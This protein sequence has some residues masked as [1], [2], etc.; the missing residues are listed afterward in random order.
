[1]S[2]Q[3]GDSDRSDEILAEQTRLWRSGDCVTV[4]RLLERYPELR[5]MPSI[6][7]DLIYNEFLLRADSGE[8]PSQSDFYQRFPE[9][10]DE[11]RL[12][13]E[14]DS[15]FDTAGGTTIS[16]HERTTDN[17]QVPSVP[18]IP[19]YTV[20]NKVRSGGMAVVY[21]ARCLRLNRIVALKVVRPEFRGDERQAARFQAEA[22][23]IAQLD[24]PH[25]V[26]I[27]EVGECDGNPYL[28]LEYVEGPL[29]DPAVAD[30]DRIRNLSDLVKGSP[31]EAKDAARLMRTVAQAVQFAHDHGIIHRDLKPS[32]ILMSADGI[33]KVAD[34]GLAKSVNAPVS[35]TKTDM[36]LGTL[37]YMPPE[38]ITSS[39]YVT[40][41]ADIYALGAT[42]YEMLTGRPPFDSEN[43]AKLIRQIAEEEARSLRTFA[44]SVPLELDSICLKCLEKT[45]QKRYAS[46]GELAD[47][48]QRF[49]NGEPTQAR[50][51]GRMN[52][53]WRWTL[54]HR[55]LATSITVAVLL[56]FA[57]ATAS[58][59]AVI[60][61]A[62][63]ARKDT[64]LARSDAAFSKEQ[65]EKERAQRQQAELKIV[66]EEQTNQL[67]RQKAFPNIAQ[68]ANERTRQFSQGAVLNF[69][70]AVQSADTP[71]FRGLI[72]REIPRMLVPV[73]TSSR[74]V[75]TECVTLHPDG[76]LL[77]SGDALDGNIRLWN[78][79]DESKQVVL[80]GHRRPEG[81]KKGYGT[82]RGLVF[83]PDRPNELISAGLDGT[84]RVWSLESQNGLIQHAMETRRFP[85]GD[86]PSNDLTANPN[87]ASDKEEPSDGAQF[88]TLDIEPSSEKTIE[89]RLVIGDNRG[90]L[91]WR[92]VDS[93]RRIGDYKVAHEGHIN[94]ARYRPDGRECA[95]A[96]ADGIVRFWNA[97]GEPIGELQ[98]N[99]DK[100]RA[101]DGPE[102]KAKPG[103][104]IFDLTYS[105]DG[106][107]LA[108][109]ASNGRVYVADVMA[110]KDREW[111]RELSGH[112][113][114]P[115][116][117]ILGT[118]CV[119]YARDH[120]LW[121]AGTDGL[122]REWDTRT[123]EELRRWDEHQPGGGESKT[124]FALDLNR[125]K[126]I[127]VSVG[128]DDR[129]VVWNV[130]TGAVQGS[131]SGMLTMR[132]SF[133]QL[134]P[135]A[136]CES[137]DLLIGAGFGRD[138]F[139]RTIDTQTLHESRKFPGLP[140]LKEIDHFP[141]RVHALAVHP[142][143]SRFVSAEPN[144]DL[145]IWDT[146][147]GE[148]VQT[149]AQA[150][151]GGDDGIPLI[152][153]MTGMAPSRAVAALAWSPSGRWI[154]SEGFDGQLQLIDPLTGK[155]V[156]KWSNSDA[157]APEQTVEKSSVVD[158]QGAKGFGSAPLQLFREN[159][160]LFDRTEQFL[161][162]AGKDSVIRFWD[163]E[164]HEI[165]HRLAAHP[166]RVTA[167]ALS[168]DGQRLVTGSE[169]G[170][171]IEWDLKRHVPGKI[172]SLS[173]LIAPIAV[174]M[175]HAPKQTQKSNHMFE[176]LSKERRSSVASLAWSP[177]EAYLAIV[178]GDGSLTIV[179]AT[180]GQIETRSIGHENNALGAS[181]VSAFF[182]RHGNLLT[183][184]SD[185][186][187]R[188]WDFAAWGE[189][190][191]PRD[192]M[193]TPNPPI[194]G[195]NVAASTDG[196]EWA[197]LVGEE[198]VRWSRSDGKRLPGWK[199]K[200]D[201]ASAAVYARRQDQS[202]MVVTSLR[203]RAVVLDCVTG[204]IVAEFKGP[205]GQRK[206]QPLPQVP[207]EVSIGA[208][209]KMLVDPQ[210][211]PRVPISAAAVHPKL[212][213]AATS[214]FKGVVELWSLESG[215]SLKNKAGKPLQLRLPKAGDEPGAN[216]GIAALAF[217]PSQP[218][219]AIAAD[220]GIVSLWNTNTGE[221]ISDGWI[222]PPQPLGLCY[223]PDGSQLVECGQGARV[224]VWGTKKGLA[225]RNLE[226]HP[227]VDPISA[228]VPAVAVSPD[229]NWFAT[230]GTDGAIRLWDVGTGA[231]LF[232]WSTTKL[233]DL[234][235]TAKPDPLFFGIQSLAF[236]ADGEQLIAGFWKGP[237]RIFEL[238][239]IR[240]ELAKEK[241][242]LQA[243][244]ER[245]TGLQLTDDG[246]IPLENNHIDLIQPEVA[247]P[248]AQNLPREARLLFDKARKAIL[249]KKAE[250][251][252]VWTN[253]SI[254]LDATNSE[255]FFIRGVA[256]LG[257]K[258]QQRALSDFNESLRLKPGNIL[259]MAYRAETLTGLKDFAKALADYNRVTELA[260][261]MAEAHNGMA[262]ILATCSD[263]KLR[264]GR[265]AVTA[266][267]KAC[268]LSKW[269][270]AGYLDTLAAAYAES[271][272]FESAI[273]WQTQ[274]LS[275]N[276]LPQEQIE[277]AHQR[278]KM[279]E[280]KQPFRQK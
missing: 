244:M 177:N 192:V 81:A 241:A 93:L 68:A 211:Q 256:W 199:E 260:P 45:P 186:T 106:Q 98:L 207:S 201:V 79:A 245:L 171:V 30:G 218:R 155:S 54:R 216:R 126:K 247:Q 234:T 184:G 253:A 26:P 277:E 105:P 200:D 7:V 160:L 14:V 146:A 227:M 242:Q 64:A 122:I 246:V 136:F 13:F 198:V 266:A 140:K 53:V 132:G 268:E 203:G 80:E 157:Q 270:V 145:F 142:D 102:D 74:R 179:N 265:K 208:I 269:K 267:T 189:Q 119:R 83:R 229:G 167:A 117:K 206:L 62:E 185:G 73:M 23:V 191:G 78:L 175:L 254:G 251:A 18:V 252:L 9:F 172:H 88:L 15:V 43:Q 141:R 39:K 12:V 8:G 262:W 232:A 21:K 237:V 61:D 235:H 118:W 49:L 47:D 278:L 187:V 109:G 230:G 250:D 181:F 55:A 159:V 28:A 197:A 240:A 233:A 249:E 107:E 66:A 29:K 133:A 205:D 3:T 94:V 147:S 41:A 137:R 224:T 228:R 100:P 258:Q 272:D 190:V 238:K 65:A 225:L 92:N 226:G 24:H 153:R 4:E 2:H 219:L 116:P 123:G 59:F 101:A 27:Y 162:S 114:G 213:L 69:A 220:D 112:D 10:A 214:W 44:P 52:R 280:N 111:R 215:E 151:R 255:S 67:L 182:D 85:S 248:P 35:L 110:G 11:L 17:P 264:D 257:L 31:M 91:H 89:R 34:F 95:S 274:A 164:Q 82:V 223:S 194:K 217:D 84:V 166:A 202:V 108:I 131:L 178:L 168:R 33:P 204:K 36:P 173:P 58:V 97:L 96:G 195:Q 259:A 5:M 72:W 32:N 50:P 90:R 212:P 16:H 99:Q 152:V 174:L 121:S 148:K 124:V 56:F 156:A 138:A 103:L 135:V 163:I 209:V 20:L 236:R 19:G 71:A 6:I 51:I 210:R 128:M 57:F 176:I 165:A 115:T 275:A 188:R 222:G 193:Q 127:A 130:D 87:P 261:D 77:A 183:A 149:I 144:G 139:L 42:F 1:M 22:E 243:D 169:D 86:I 158:L 125:Q 46:V 38:Q 150:H 231:Q 143:G 263:D 273:K 279:Y 221:M 75:A 113:A 196:S 239:P 25:I 170:I 161:I 180:N 37:P 63:A 104:E 271:G 60:K 154:A 120:R 76:R 129:L 276:G 134:G 48:L 40:V 70:R